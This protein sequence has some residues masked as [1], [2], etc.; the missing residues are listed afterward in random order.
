MSDYGDTCFACGEDA[1]F[2]VEL[3]LLEEG[4]DAPE[5]YESYCKKCIKTE[6]H[7]SFAEMVKQKKIKITIVNTY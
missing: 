3:K 6:I 1:N 2:D 4:E 5:A 7:E